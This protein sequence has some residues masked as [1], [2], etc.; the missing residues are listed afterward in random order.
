[1]LSLLVAGSALSGSAAEIRV[2]T[3]YLYPTE[4]TVTPIVSVSPSGQTLT[5][6]GLVTPSSFEMREVGALMTVEASVV[7]LSALNDL[8]ESDYQERRR[9]NTPLIMAAARGDL[10]EVVRLVMAGAFVNVRNNMGATALTG[11]ATGGF[12]DVVDYLLRHSASVNG[13]ASNGATA[14][15][16]AARNGHVETV[17]RLLRSGADAN[18]ADRNGVTPLM[19]ASYGGFGDVVQALLSAG[20]RVG[21]RDNR[22]TT[23]IQLAQHRDHLPIVMLLTQTRARP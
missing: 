12:L 9:G 15:L 13:R 20:A 4:Y 7:N 6:G 21:A 17:Q 11:A 19:V 8:A 18:A 2:T 16:Y 5:L 23:A 22:G 3:E 10:S 14:L 1:M